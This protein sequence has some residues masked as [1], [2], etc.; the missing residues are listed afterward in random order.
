MF[1]DGT[2]KSISRTSKKERGSRSPRV[3]RRRLRL[4]A[5]FNR[6]SATPTHGP[7][8]ASS[9]ASRPNG[10][11]RRSS[12]QAHPRS[13]LT[14]T[15]CPRCSSE[16][17]QKVQG[18]PVERRARPRHSPMTHARRRRGTPL[19]LTRLLFITAP[20]LFRV[21]CFKSFSLPSLGAF[22]LSLT[23]LVRY[24]SQMSI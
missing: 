8:I 1:Q 24:R 18:A 2:K 23:L 7:R 3:R 11:L 17:T 21:R 16:S 15:T 14:F 13:T 22:N 10:S 5:I 9:I 6:D 19:I 20:L 12:E 4:R